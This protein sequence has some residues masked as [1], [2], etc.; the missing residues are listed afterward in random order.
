ML[1]TP[2]RLKVEKV[3]WVSGLKPRHA[4]D[5]WSKA[6]ADILLDLFDSV[7]KF[8]TTL[9]AEAGLGLP[10]SWYW[11]VARTD[12]SYGF[13]VFFWSS[14]GT[15]WRSDHR[16]ICPFDTG[17]LWHGH[18][19]LTPEVVDPAAKRAF[20]ERHDQGLADWQV[21]FAT[22]LANNY[23]SFA[24]YVNGK[25]PGVGIPE[26]R[27][28]SNGPLAWSWEARLDRTEVSGRVVVSRLYCSVE[29]ERFFLNWLE[30]D[31]SLDFATQRNV[32]R[33]FLGVRSLCPDAVA[34]S[35]AAKVA[36]IDEHE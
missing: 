28:D 12:D 18:V 1:S 13:T 23:G 4:Y 7:G 16:G 17:G 24:D 15:V 14:H 33:R 11:F 22:Y 26:I 9:E 32:R 5:R 21:A 35:E 3:P 10:P 27:P 8:D 30:E 6:V 20:F 31:D 2:S 29:S 19:H 34:P 36:L 25:P